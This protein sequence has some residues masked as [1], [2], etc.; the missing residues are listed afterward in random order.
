M[1]RSEDL[2]AEIRRPL[3]APLGYVDVAAITY[4]LDIVE[5]RYTVHQLRRRSPD[6]RRAQLGEHCYERIKRAIARPVH[7]CA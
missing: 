4:A 1:Y 3:N 5:I 2:A 6:Q 7:D